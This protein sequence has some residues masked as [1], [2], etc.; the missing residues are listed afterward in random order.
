MVYGK[1][2]VLWLRVEGVESYEREGERE[3]ERDQNPKH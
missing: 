2:Q 1:D 3:G